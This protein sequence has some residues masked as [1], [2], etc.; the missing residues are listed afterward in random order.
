MES[1][2]RFLAA[3]G[4][5]PRVARLCRFVFPD[6]VRLFVIKYAPNRIRGPNCSLARATKERK[7]VRESIFDGGIPKTSKKEKKAE[8]TRLLMKS[9]LQHIVLF[10]LLFIF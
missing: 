1:G 10:C 2:A 5:E 4:G 7:R 3:K 9:M 8:R 6:N